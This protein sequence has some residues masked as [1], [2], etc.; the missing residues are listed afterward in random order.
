MTIDRILNIVVT[1]GRDYAD[2]EMVYRAL[3]LLRPTRV[4]HGACSTKRGADWLSDD[5]CRE[6]GVPC[7]PYP[8]T[9]YNEQGVF[10][11]SAGP[12][13]NLLMLQSE[14]P[15]LVVAFPGGRGTADC[16]RQA[17]QLMVVVFEVKP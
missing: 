15:Q 10:E 9:W 6:N 3:N 2:R 7:K 17:R 4:A 14:L 1:G 16:V 8:A 13:R 5:W 11:R 12:R